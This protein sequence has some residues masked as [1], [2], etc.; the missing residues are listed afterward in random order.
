MVLDECPPYPCERSACQAAVEHAV[1]WAGEF[2]HRTKNDGFWIGG[3]M[4]LPYYRVRVMKIY[5]KAA[6]RPWPRW[7]FRAMRWAE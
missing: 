5:A 2:L 4:Y 3:I 7:I 6:A 1:R